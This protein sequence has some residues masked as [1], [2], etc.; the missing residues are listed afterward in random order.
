[1]KAARLRSEYGFVW[2]ER[3]ADPRSPGQ[4][5]LWRFAPQQASLWAQS[6]HHSKSETEGK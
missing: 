1:M 4:R 6:Q 5:E 2:L 3:G